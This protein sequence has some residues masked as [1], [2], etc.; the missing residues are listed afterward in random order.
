MQVDTIFDLSSLT[1]PLAT[2]NAFMLLLGERKLQLDDRVTRFFPN[3]GVHGKTHVT[4]RHLLAHCSGL[5]GWRPFHREV[6]RVERQGRLNFVASRGAKEF[7]YEQIHRE[8]PEYETGERAVYSDLGFM[9]LGEAIELVSRMP[10]DRVCQERVFRPLGLRAMSF[11]DLSEL[12]TRRLTPV[13]DMIAPTA[14]CPSRKRLLFGEVDD[15]NAYAMGGVAGHAGLFSSAADIHTLV[16]RLEACHRGEDTFIPSAIVRD[17]WT[18]DRTVRDST[19]ALGWDMPSPQ[20]SSA[21]R[22]ISRTAVGHLGFTGTSLWIDLERDVHVV[23]LT[24]RVH[25]SRDNDRIRDVRP[26]VHDA[27]MEALDR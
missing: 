7:V 16:T 4:F 26:R 15:E 17:F 10:L 23:L 2:V 5:A 27:V 6:A 9:L 1:K 3:F 14:F 13:V 12:R 24:N 8:R 21:G 22:H 20:A 11:I 19:W 25:P 18:R